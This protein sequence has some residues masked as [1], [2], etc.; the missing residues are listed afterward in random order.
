VCSWVESE[1]GNA[2]EREKQM[3][4]TVE[5]ELMMTLVKTVL[6]K[7]NYTS[8]EKEDETSKVTVQSKQDTF[9]NRAQ[10]LTIAKY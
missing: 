8:E 2:K 4:D 3:I 10:I 7:T 6:S 5:K 1:T 9:K